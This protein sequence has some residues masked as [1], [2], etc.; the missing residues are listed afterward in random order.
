M[1]TRASRRQSLT[2]RPIVPGDFRFIRSLASIIDG[3]TVPS[4]Y[5]SWMLGRF[6]GG[7]CAVA[8]DTGHNR[9]G[10]V[11]AMPTSDPGDGVFVWQLA[12]TFRGRRLKAQDHL[13][14]HL[15]KA[16]RARNAH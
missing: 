13:A 12:V 14:A 16:M 10:Y 7:L 8:A 9:L 3:Y 6:H 1:V 11:L 4:P 5:V 2:V 15:K